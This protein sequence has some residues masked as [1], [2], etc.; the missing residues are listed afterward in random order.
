[1]VPAWIP[2]SGARK[3]SVWGPEWTNVWAARESR[4]A[5]FIVN[6]IWLIDNLRPGRAMMQIGMIHGDLHAGNVLLRDGESPAIIDF[7]WSE[8]RAHVSKDFVLME[9]NLRFHMLKPQLSE[10]DLKPF[11]EWLPEDDSQPETNNDYLRSR[12]E[13]VRE[14]HRAARVVLGP[15]ADWTKEYLVP[16]FFVSFGL[17]RFA[18]QLGNQRAAVRFVE[19]LAGHIATA[20]ESDLAGVAK[21]ATMAVFGRVGGR[22]CLVPRPPRFNGA[23]ASPRPPPRPTSRLAARAGREWPASVTP[24]GCR[25]VGG[26]APR[27]GPSPA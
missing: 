23:A 1:M 27:V 8:A 14:V 6:P 18:P 4:M 17:L 10:G 25:S 16:L 19:S 12:M 2:F 9:C 26:Q 3:G 21:D 24:T 5:G 15:D 13:L 20:L 22:E 11:V 7:G